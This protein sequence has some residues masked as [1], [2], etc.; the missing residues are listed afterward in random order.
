MFVC[1]QDQWKSRVGTS[2]CRNVEV[3]FAQC[4]IWQ[5][6]ETTSSLGNPRY[7]MDD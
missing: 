7:L 5:D 4:M 1:N 2:L 6:L 3:N